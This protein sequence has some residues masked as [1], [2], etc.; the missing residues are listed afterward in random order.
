VSLYAELKRRNV[1]RVAVAYLASAWL[2]I[3][4]ADTVFP[5][6]N[7]PSSALTLLITVLAIGLVPVVVI[8]WVFELTPEGFRR[9]EGVVAGAPVAPRDAKWLDRAIMVVLALAIGYFAFDKFVLDPA[10]DAAQ[11][12]EA[13]DRGRAAAFIDSYGDKSIAV[14]PFVNMSADVEQEYFSDGVAEDLLNRLAKVEGL[15]VISRTSSFQLRHTDLSVPEIAARLGVAHVLEGSVR[16]SGNQVRITAQLID[17]RADAHLWSETYDRELGDIFAIQDEIA[18]IIVEQLQLSLAAELPKSE[19]HNPEAYPLYLQARH[20]T[21]LDDPEEFDRAET[22]LN[23]ALAMEPEYVDAQLELALLYDRK[24]WF[25][26]HAGDDALARELL[27]AKKSILEEVTGREPG[28]AHLNVMLCWDAFSG[29]YGQGSR[30]LAAAARFCEAALATDPRY[31]G[32]LLMAMV[33]FEALGQQERVLSIGE[34]LA[35]RDPMGFWVHALLADAYLSTGEHEQGLA[36]YRIAAA[37]SPR[38]VGI[39]WKLG[40]ALLLNGRPQEAL[41][42]F[43]R[44]EHDAYRLHGRAMALNDLGDAEGSAAALAELHA[45]KDDEALALWPWG[46]ARLY[47]WLGDADKAFEYLQTVLEV[48]PAGLAGLAANPYFHKIHDDPRWQPLL[49]AIARQKPDF[50]FNPRLPPEVL[51]VNAGK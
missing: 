29:S 16:K 20:V 25:V 42:H 35:S 48:E 18:R 49:D 47:A 26:G 43:D 6:Y 23:Q 1:I 12:R 24:A 37:V 39:Q 8:S 34:Y 36:A 28:N 46:F 10:R 9:D 38:A 41:E 4:V 19:R 7:L 27:A 51:A 11:Q 31:D 22:L 3:E 15:R 32:A 14:L 40:F 17:A 5:A 2:L 13:E 44:D 30:D 33:L 21:K 45:I 50:E